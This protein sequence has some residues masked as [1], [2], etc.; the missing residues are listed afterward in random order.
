MALKA[1]VLTTPLRWMDFKGRLNSSPLQ[2][3]HT[4]LTTEPSLQL[5]GIF[6][7]IFLKAGEKGKNNSL[8]FSSNLHTHAHT[9]PTT[10]NT[11]RATH[12]LSKCNKKI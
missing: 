1:E 8:K 6:F 11:Y 7:K 4:L 2:A 10:H 9:H 3:Q 5:P 12:K